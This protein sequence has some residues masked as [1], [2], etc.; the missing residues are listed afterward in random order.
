VV[1]GAATLLERRVGL[2]EDDRQAEPLERPEARAPH[3]DHDP[4]PAGP[5]L[6]PA[7]VQRALLVV[8]AQVDDQVG[9]R[10]HDPVG[11]RGRGVGDDDQRVAVAGEAELDELADPGG[12]VLPGERAPQVRPGPAGDRVPQ[13]AAGLAVA[14]PGGVEPAAS[15]AGS[16]AARRAVPGGYHPASVAAR[17]T[18]M[19]RRGSA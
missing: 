18:S 9:R 7:P 2:V 1:A 4:G 13:L 10:G 12:E 8:V 16:D 3:P 19:T 5:G 11:R 15:G 14:R 17:S 6:E